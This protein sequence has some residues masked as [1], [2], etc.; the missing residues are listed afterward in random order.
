[1]EFRA[2]CSD[3]GRAMTKA[4][5]VVTG[6][7]MS[8]SSQGTQARPLTDPRIERLRLHA[9]REGSLPEQAATEVVLGAYAA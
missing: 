1:M 3:A 6:L 7:R 9:D 2:A 8:R 5:R 4:A